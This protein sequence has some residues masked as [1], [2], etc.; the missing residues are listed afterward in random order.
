M[1]KYYT[2]QQIADLHPCYSQKKLVEL[3]DGKPKLHFD[4]IWTIDIPDADKVWM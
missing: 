4:T 1:K 2:M 3:F